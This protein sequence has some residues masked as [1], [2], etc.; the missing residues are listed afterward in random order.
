ML[1][2]FIYQDK[3]LHEIRVFIILNFNCDAIIN[4]TVNAFKYVRIRNFVFYILYLNIILFIL[5]YT[6]V[7]DTFKVHYEFTEMQNVFKNR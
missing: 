2:I 3:I 6:R 4:T 7:S 5:I 1:P